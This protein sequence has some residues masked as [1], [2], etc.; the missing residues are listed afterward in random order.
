MKMRE[1]VNNLMGK[2]V[3]NISLNKVNRILNGYMH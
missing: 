3:G 2:T 1:I